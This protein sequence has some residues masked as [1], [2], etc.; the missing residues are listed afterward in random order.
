MDKDTL[1]DNLFR[2]YF[3]NQDGI[4][5]SDLL[6]TLSFIP[7]AWKKLHE[8]CEEN[9]E[10]FDSFSNLEQCKLIQMNDNV[11]LILKFGILNYIVI[12]LKQRKNISRQLI[13]KDFNNISTFNNPEMLIDF[14]F[15]NQQILNLSTSL[16]YKIFIDNAWTYF[17]VDFINSSIQLGFQTSDQFLYEHLFLNY[18]LTASRMQDAKSKMG[19]EKMN[20]IFSRIK[21]IK[22]PIEVIPSDL[23]E[24]YKS[25]KELIR[26]L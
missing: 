19:T 26:K 14:Y 17:F 1:R 13:D 5:A 8:M 11:Y 21:T 16:E 2:K 15:Q 4:E 18:D 23:Y 7:E 20:E 10:Y 12:D 6:T 22:I 24:Q 9:I 3:E 25:Q